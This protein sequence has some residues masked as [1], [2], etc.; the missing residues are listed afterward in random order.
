[1]IAVPVAI[2]VVIVIAGVTPTIAAVATAI[3]AVAIAAVAAAVIA[4]VAA[5]VGDVHDA[6]QTLQALLQVA[7][8]PPVQP[9]VI[10]AIKA[11][12]SAKA[13]DLLKELPRFPLAIGAVPQSVLDSGV[14]VI[15]LLAEPDP[16]AAFPIL[17]IAVAVAATVAAAIV[18][19]AVTAAQTD[20]V[21]CDSGSRQREN[22]CGKQ[23]NCKLFHGFHLQLDGR[24]PQDE[25]RMPPPG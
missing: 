12:Q 17:G 8:L 19:A 1:M 22:S 24:P 25:V 10:G 11:L 6:M 13:F 20:P 23:A 3:T 15:E 9:A 7:T 16:P 21:L 18:A 4:T 14:D 2:V 5:L